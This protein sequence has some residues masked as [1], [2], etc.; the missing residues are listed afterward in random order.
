MFLVYSFLLTLSRV[1]FI[2][3]IYVHVNILTALIVIICSMWTAHFGYYCHY[4]EAKVSL[5]L[6][7]QLTHAGLD[8]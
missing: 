5:S 1:V 8:F 6:T 2:S 7:A 4:Q 3:I